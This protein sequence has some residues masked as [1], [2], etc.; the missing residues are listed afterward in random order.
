MTFTPLA[1]FKGDPTPVTY[2]VTATNGLHAT[3]TVT[4]TYVPV[5]VDDSLSGV[6]IGAPATVSPLTNDDGDFVG[7]SLRLIDPTTLSPVTGPVV[8]AGQ[9][10]WTISGTDVIFTPEPGFLTDPSPIGYQITDTTG[11]TV[12]ANITITSV[13]S[14]TDDSSLGNALGS[15]VNLNVLA[16]D[17]GSWDTASLVFVSRPRDVAGR[18]G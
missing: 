11:D 2:R 4:I 5:A 7:S 12:S 8:V 15:T 9:G 14:A 16:N 18:A 3:A 13:P 17:T 10:T 1:S 6:A